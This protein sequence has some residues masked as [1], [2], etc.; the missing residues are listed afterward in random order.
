MATSTRSGIPTEYAGVA[1]RSRLEAKWAAFFD[2]VG[3]SWVYEPIDAPGYIPDFLIQGRHPFFVEVGPCATL[4]EY[5]DKSA[6]ASGLFAELG[7]DMLIVGTSPIVPFL[8]PLSL[9]ASAGWFGE[10]A[11]DGYAWAPAAWGRCYDCNQ[12]GVTHTEMSFNLRSCGHHQSGGWGDPIEPDW[13]TAL[14]RRAGNDTQWAARGPQSVG[15]I[16]RA[17]R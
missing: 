14:W 6:K 8:S 2:L 12:I 16:I 9:H 15:S 17:L 1:F 7:R 3:W 13:L 5:E 11:A 10:H 4:A